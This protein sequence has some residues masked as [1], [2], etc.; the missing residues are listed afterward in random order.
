MRRGGSLATVGL[1]SGR[2]RGSRGRWLQRVR[3]EKD[4]L[5]V[6]RRGS[7][8]AGRDRGEWDASEARW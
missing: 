3:E 5:W 7:D 8:R 6:C 1:V 4:V 2:T